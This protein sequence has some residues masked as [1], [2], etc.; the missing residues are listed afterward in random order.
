MNGAEILRIA[1]PKGS[2]RSAEQRKSDPGNHN[3]RDDWGH[4]SAPVAHGQAKQTFK[5]SSDQHGTGYCAIAIFC[6]NCRERNHKGKT[7]P[8]EHRQAGTELPNWCGL[9]NGCDS[10]RDHGALHK[11]EDLCFCQGRRC[12]CSDNADRDQIRDKHREDLLQGKR[13]NH[14]EPRIPL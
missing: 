2:C 5:Q 12:G 7:H 4:H 10:G 13:Q 9:K 3:R 14:P 1:A 6:R 8:H 11:A